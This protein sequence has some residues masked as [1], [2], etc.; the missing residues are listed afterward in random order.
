MPRRRRGNGRNLILAS[1]GVME[2]E[3]FLRILSCLY[4]NRKTTFLH[5]KKRKEKKV[6]NWCNAFNFSLGAF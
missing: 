5:G 4:L 2:E 6:A 1:F 3:I